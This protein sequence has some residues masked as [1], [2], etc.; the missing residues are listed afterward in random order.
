MKGG[1]I[2]SYVFYIWLWINSIVAMYI[3]L[4]TK[5][6]QVFGVIGFFG[7]INTWVLIRWN[8]YLKEME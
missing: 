1:K 3:I 7:F 5:D 2:L 4:T 8:K 6:V